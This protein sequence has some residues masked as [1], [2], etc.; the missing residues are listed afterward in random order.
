VKRT[1]RRRPEPEPVRS[2]PDPEVE[3]QLA[4]IRQLQQRLT[5]KAR[6]IDTYQT[7]IGMLHKALRGHS[8]KLTS[9]SIDQDTR[10]GIDAAIEADDKRA[11]HLQGEIRVLEQ[12]MD[13]VQDDIGTRM[14]KLS[15]SDLAFL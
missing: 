6:Q 5:V 7:E 11:K 4:R 9:T 13:Q 10:K 8:R 3:R 1:G 2:H 12:D 14:G 15:P